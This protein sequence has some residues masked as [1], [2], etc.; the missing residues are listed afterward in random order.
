MIRHGI[1][2]L[3][4]AFAVPASAA[5]H[6]QESDYYKIRTLPVPEDV[7]LEPG[8]FELMPDG[9]V[10]VCSRRG[11]I[12]MIHNAFADDPQKAGFRRYAHGLHEALGLAW[13][14]NGWLYVTH[15]PAV[16]RLQD[17]DDDGR[18]DLFETVYDG[19]GM[20]G[21]YHE[22]A[23]SSKFDDNGHLWVALCL[24]GSFSSQAPYRGWALRITPDG[25]MI[26][27]CSGLRSPGGLGR[28]AEGDMFM[29]DNQGPWNGTCS[30]KHLKPGSF[31]GHPAGNEWYKLSEAAEAMGPRPQEPE[32]GSRISTEAEKIPEYV[33]PA[34][35]FP[36]KKMGQSASGITC[37]TTGGKF[38]PFEGQLFVGDQTH[39]T[40]MRCYLEKVDGRYQGACFPFRSGFA[41]GSLA[42]LMTPQGKM[43]VGGTSRGWGSRGTK[44]YSVERLD[45]TGKVP[46]EV[47]EMRARPD[48][49][50]LKFTKP[51]DAETAT[52][53]DSY[54][55]ETY[56]Y[57][58]QSSYGSPEVDHTQPTITGITK[59]DERTVRLAIDGLQKGHVHELH[60]DGVRSAGELPLLHSRAYYTLNSVPE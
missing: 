42:L 2:L 3:I 38:G 8:D 46:F 32:S 41:S 44:P 54:S 9:R 10:A 19:W 36:Y 45:W 7:V 18:A 49:F 58:Y 13:H 55:I 17:S 20:S 48:G 30:L 39:S 43:F 47:E 56:T 24:T 25:E 21:D 37:D 40:V 5:E 15:R 28:N 22:Y 59:Q 33:P 14:E 34:I 26:P 12:Y 11:E 31:Q 35:L 51:V 50:E 53:T 29:T 16:T 57:I 27:T 6:P 4:V 23:F 52:D 60:L 1:F